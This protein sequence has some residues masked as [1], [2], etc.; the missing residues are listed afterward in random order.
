MAAAA[1]RRARSCDWPSRDRRP[2]AAPAIPRVA[3]PARPPRGG[4]SWSCRVPDRAPA[5]ACRRHGPPARPGH[6]GRSPRPM[7]SAKTPRSLPSR[8]ASNDRARRRLGHRFHSAGTTADDRNI[9]RPE[10][11]RAAQVRAVRARSAR[12]ALAPG[13][14]SRRPGSS[15]LAGR[16]DD[17]EVGGHVLEHLPLVLADPAQH[18]AATGRA[19][20]GRLVADG[21]AWQML[22]E[23]TCSSHNLLK[24]LNS[25]WVR[26]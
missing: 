26:R 2:P 15:S 20:A 16:G 7:A 13:Q 12:T 14:S 8:P 23:E 19:A 11:A 25:F 3:R 18:R 24:S 9:S 10:H 21:L 6:D 5:P 22:P 4:R 17:L 1:L